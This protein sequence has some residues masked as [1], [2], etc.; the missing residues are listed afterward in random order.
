MKIAVLSGKGG[1]GKTFVSANLAVSAGRSTYIDCDVE[2]PNGRLFLK[3]Q[4]VENKI[5][6]RCLPEFR[7]DRCD[8]CRKCVD[9]CQFHALVYVKDKPMLFSEVCHSCGG[10]KLVCPQD[11][12]IEAEYELGH[13]ETGVHEQVHVVT[14]ILNIGEA[15][16]IAVIKAAKKEGFQREGLS[17]VDCPPGSACSVNESIGDADYCILVAEPTS[18]G[19]H[20]FKMVYELVN[21]LGKKCGIIINKQDLPY[22]P[23]EKFCIENQIEILARIPYDGEAAELSAKG[24]IVCEEKEE[25]RLLFR[26]ILKKIGGERL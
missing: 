18:F 6:Y 4:N 24:K 7:E 13:V 23:M 2:E 11:A 17:I 26:D 3:P 22:E 21:L 15:S 9:F 8:G 12:V 10:C 20:N 19:F 25:Y 14:G 16:G 5:V 1:A